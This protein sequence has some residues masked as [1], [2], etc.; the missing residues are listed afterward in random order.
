[1]WLLLFV[2]TEAGLHA[3]PNQ[4]TDASSDRVIA[5]EDTQLRTCR[6]GLLD[7]KSRPEER[8]RWAELLFSYEGAPA[9]ALI[10]DLLGNSVYPEV[11]RALCGV[12]AER[13]SREPERLDPGLVVPLVDLLGAAA[14]D[15]R[16]LAGRILADFTGTDVPKR[17]GRLAAEPTEPLAK[18]LAAIDALARN[19]HRRDVVGQLVGL[20]DGDAPEV[21]ASVVAA[22]ESTTPQTFGSDLVR[23]KR[24]WAEKSHLSEEVWSAEQLR[25]YRDRSRRIATE[26]AIFR[27]DTK[28]EEAA[29]TDRISAMER[30][31][32]RTVGGDEQ[33][34]KLVEWLRDPLDVVRRTALSIVGARIPDEGKRPQGEVLTA[35]LDVFREGP[36][37]LRREVLAIVQNL[38]DSDVL[39]ALLDRLTSEQDLPTRLAIFRAI[40]KL[41]QS[42]AIPALV[43][44]IASMAAF[45]E[46][47]REASMALGSVAAKASDERELQQAVDALK[48][49]YGTT[50]SDDGRMRAALLTAM[51]GIGH[52]AFRAEF[53]ESVESS[54]PILLQP[55]IRG[56]VSL[57]DATKL[58]RLRTL[59]HHDD[60]LVRLAATD[61]VGELGSEDVDLENLVVR[62]NPTVETNERTRDAA[63]SGFLQQME[64][65]SIAERIAAAARLRELPDF[66]VRFLEDL[67]DGIPTANGESKQLETVLDRLTITLVAQHRY[68][69]AVPRLRALCELQSSHDEPSTL[70]CGLRLLDAVLRDSVST[71][72]AEL[73]RQLAASV[74]SE[75]DKIELVNRVKTYLESEHAMANTK[76]LR[77]LL[78]DLRSI[79]SR[80]LGDSWQDTLDSVD[81]RLKD[82][83]K[84]KTS[85][86]SQSQSP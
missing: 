26:F 70:P 65:R 78:V 48:T 49:R 42:K 53:L 75:R 12:L 57:K 44:E 86:T 80:V 19:T 6:E 32:F 76:R 30:E 84:N 14:D 45:P 68:T 34:A 22:L 8:A 73:I 39:D 64:R 28:R 21:A 16:S 37:P 46:C 13:A 31:L 41:D 85:D 55:A 83:D 66:E 82:S 62:L 67:A 40:G 2:L 59:T 63:W 9:K 74:P 69:E 35:L 77:A 43:R 38:K 17:L 52:V 47:V 58:P 71:G 72:V 4:V 23:W 3:A 10:I 79:P 81:Q 29:L 27:E 25:L 11:Q 15:L 36:A 60:A 50:G 5:N 56:L 24:W 51:A 18:R 33:D 7:P 20:L 1:M 61:A 54:D